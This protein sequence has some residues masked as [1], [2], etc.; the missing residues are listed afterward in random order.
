MNALSASALVALGGAIGA[1]MRF[2]LA[3]GVVGWLGA[4][5]PFA[6]FI[7]N[8]TG[9]FIIGA[10]SVL[11]GGNPP[12]VAFLITGVLGGFTTFST[13]SL[14]TVRL[15]EAGRVVDGMGYAG[16]S[17]VACVIGAAL[18]MLAARAVA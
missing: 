6:T 10:A 18:G 7:T 14:E 1:L 11:I 8:V 17:V 13:F 16:L 4:H 15:L 12:V 9:S 2:W 3:V 5:L